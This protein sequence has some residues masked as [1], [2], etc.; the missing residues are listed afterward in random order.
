M[1][2]FKAFVFTVDA[3]FALII[4]SAATS[5]LVLTAYMPPSQLQG[6]IAE[7]TSI[8]LNFLQATM[9][10]MV[11]GIP[12][13]AAAVHGWDSMQYTWPQYGNNAGESSSTG[14]F[15]PQFPFVLFSYQTRGPINPAPAVA[16]GLVVFSTNGVGSN[17]YAV[18]ATT[19]TLV[20]NTPDPFGGVFI[21]APAIYH[22]E[23]YV[24]DSNGI[25]E[26]YSENGLFL[27]GSQ[28]FGLNN[29][30]LEAENGWIETN[31]TFI[32]P[33]NGSALVS[34]P[35]HQA[36]YS[37]GEYFTVN[38]VAPGNLEG[39]SL[40]GNT[41]TQL[42]S[43]DLYMSPTSS[44]VPIATDANSVYVAIANT[45]GQPVL[46]SYDFGGAQRWTQVLSNYVQGGA[47]SSGNIV[48]VK[49]SNTLYGYNQT[50]GYPLYTTAFPTDTYTVTPS[51]TPAYVY[52]ETQGN[53]LNAYNDQTGAL[54][55]NQT[56]LG[57][58]VPTLNA[59]TLPSDIAIAYGNAYVVSGNVL[60]AIGTCKADPQSSILQ[61][62]A[63]MYLNGQGGCADLLLNKSYGS[64]KVAVEINGSYAPSLK[65]VKFSGGNY[66][67]TNPGVSGG[68][69]NSY[70]TLSLWVYPNANIASN[71]MIAGFRNQYN[72]DFYVMQ[73][74][75][76]NT[77]QTAYRNSAGTFFSTTNNNILAPNRWNNVIFVYNGTNI[78]TYVNGAMASNEAADG[79]I[80]NTSAW[81][82]IGAQLNGGI[83]SN[84]FNGIV[85]DV[86]L[87]N[88]A[89][90]LQQV[91]S[92]YG[93]GTGGAPMPGAVNWWPLEG[94]TNDYISYDYGYN[95]GT[96]SFVNVPSTPPGIQ[97][98]Y[99][100][101]KTSVPLVI[102][103]NGTYHTYNV[104]LV[105]WR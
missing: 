9:G 102:G 32:S 13:A 18:N 83:E 37:N 2:N 56:L 19:G 100:V 101:S 52:T 72:A 63:T 29:L 85:S 41:L 11:T 14:G 57:G 82:T 77:V 71:G 5:I 59:N 33:V 7:S 76:T 20:F 80:T 91:Y 67:Y 95:S 16:D 39:F 27:R 96:N 44:F 35:I 53:V 24:A 65:S 55:W 68:I 45:V 89:L 15:G 66:I 26:A 1:K 104:G 61:A 8:S 99:L 69:A 12:L 31:L 70:I 60:Y 23:I 42:W 92:L 21:G 73:I 38:T 54:V 93:E 43:S 105:V 22:G 75:G 58:G 87:Y 17:L 25:V 90:D 46:T 84:M 48:V 28:I 81:F 49:T 3:I 86:Q 50:D 103:V 51:I 4:A 64:N 62:I 74:A 36:A 6:P 97:N 78:T 34:V 79:F 94:D 40:Y 10:Q 88:T 30:F 98:A 47:A